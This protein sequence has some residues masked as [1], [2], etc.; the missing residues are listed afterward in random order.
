[1]SIKLDLKPETEALLIAQATMQG[2]SV[3]RYLESLI[4]SHLA[5]QAEPEWKAILDQLGRSPSL[6][7]APPLSDE[8]ISRESI[9]QEREDRQL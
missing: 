2:V 3:N 9:Y 5:T 6:A 4:E 7:K 1:M 8:A